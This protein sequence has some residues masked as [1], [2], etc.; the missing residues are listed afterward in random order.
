MATFFI[1]LISAGAAQA[2]FVPV[3]PMTFVVV[4]TENKRQMDKDQCHAWHSKY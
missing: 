1:I 3:R 4:T 2:I